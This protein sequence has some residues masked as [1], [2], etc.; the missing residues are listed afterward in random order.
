MIL[1]V[2]IA[3]SVLTLLRALNRM[4]P[5]DPPI[6]SYVL[7]AF[8]AAQVGVATVLPNVVTATGARRVT[9]PAG[10]Y[11]LYQTRL[12][13]RLAPLEGAALALS[14]AWYVEG[15]P[16]TM[17]VALMFNGLMILQYPT[18]GRVERWVEAQKELAYQDRTPS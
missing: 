14:I 3:F 7:L 16:V 6:I 9:E 1:G 11:A 12:L 5:R 10:W 15:W 8:A 18:D 2:L 17:I 4:P 13:L